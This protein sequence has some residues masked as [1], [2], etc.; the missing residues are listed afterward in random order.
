MIDPVLPND[1]T[2]EP[3]LI[4]NLK[5]KMCARKSHTFPKVDNWTWDQFTKVMYNFRYPKMIQFGGNCEP[6]LYEH[7][8]DGI[9]YFKAEGSGLCMTSNGLLMN[10]DKISKLV[11]GMIVYISIDGGTEKNYNEIR[12]NDMNIPIRNL[13]YGVNNRRDISWN[14][15]SLVMKNKIRDEMNIIDYAIRLG[16]GVDFQFPIVFSKE[17][18]DECSPFNDPNFYSDMADLI[19]YG[20]RFRVKFTHPPLAMSERMCGIPWTSAVVSVH[21]DVYPCCY[22]YISR[23]FENRRWNMF[24][25]GKGYD[26][27]QEDYVMGNIFKESFLDI[28]KGNKYR[29]IRNKLSN[30]NN[31]ID[32]LN[33]K[34][35]EDRFYSTADK[36]DPNVNLSFCDICLFRW[37]RMGNI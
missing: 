13:I 30:L 5:C 2:L 14:I 22:S 17:V 18:D 7:F 33:K 11:Q 24:Y 34:K 3:S 12:D 26:V 8:F 21:G 31:N 10:E 6:L 27:N 28:W 25:K 32:W 4:C 19:E 29:S 23:A 37:G 9:N 36:Y 15:N 35:Q 20:K 1:I 16:I